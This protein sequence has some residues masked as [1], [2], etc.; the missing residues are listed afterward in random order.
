MMVCIFALLLLNEFLTEVLCDF[1][2]LGKVLINL[3]SFVNISF[4]S[5]AIARFS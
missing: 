4:V 2:H 5:G 3:Y 1:S